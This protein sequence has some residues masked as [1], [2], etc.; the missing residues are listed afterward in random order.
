VPP[1]IGFVTIYCPFTTVT[2]AETALQLFELKSDGLLCNVNPVEFV[3]QERMRLVPFTAK[4]N[5]GGCCAGGVTLAHEVPMRNSSKIPFA[6]SDALRLKSTKLAMTPELTSPPTEDVNVGA[7]ANALP[8][9]AA[10]GLIHKLAT[11]SFVLA[12]L[13]V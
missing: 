1:E 11:S 10:A 2:G 13:N 3:L 5:H 6:G 7:G 9:V 8:N 4:F 12:V